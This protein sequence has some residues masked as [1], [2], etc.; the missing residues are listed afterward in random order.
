MP[1]VMRRGKRR[2]SA[3]PRWGERPLRSSLAKK[4]D[5]QQVTLSLLSSFSYQP[6]VVA[7]QTFLIIGQ[8]DMRQ[9]SPSNPS[10]SDTAYIR[11]A[12]INL[13]WGT[14]PSN[15]TNSGFFQH[16][17]WLCKM[18]AAHSGYMVTNNIHPDQAAFVTDD[19]VQ[20]VVVLKRGDVLIRAVNSSNFAAFLNATEGT[21]IFARRRVR[22]GPTRFTGGEQLYLLQDTTLWNGAALSA[23][24]VTLQ[25][26]FH[27]RAVH[28]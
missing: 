16:R 18:T 10:M 21:S 20:G 19:N 4:S 17:W 8:G 12:N 28:G 2:F 11:R 13:T 22:L 24:S 15:I 14:N 27:A 23:N 25:V 26:D 1:Y 9:G 5:R 3:T 6:N 7:P